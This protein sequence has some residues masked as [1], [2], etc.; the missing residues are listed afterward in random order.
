[1]HPTRWLPAALF[2]FAAQAQAL[3]YQWNDWAMT[4]NGRF[5]SGLTL[6]MQ[7]RNN[8]LIGKLNVPGQQHL[9]DIDNCLSF[10][11]DPRPNQRLVDATGAYFGVNGD[12]G[13]LNY[14]KH[15]IVAATQML[16]ADFKIARGDFLLR[17]RGIAYYD[18][19][20]TRHREHHT[21][22]LYQPDYTE[23]N[24]RTLSVFARDVR[25]MEA[26]GQYNFSLAGHN[27]VF[28]L[29][30]Q[31]VRW[32]ESTLIALNSLNEITPPNGAFLH[33]PGAQI[34][35]IFQPV[36][37]GLLSFDVA[38]GLSLDLLYQFR[39]TPVQPDA[40]GSFFSTSDIAG[41]G[42]YAMISLGAFPEDP[43]Q[44]ATPAKPSPAA[45]TAIL[46]LISSTSFSTRILPDDYGHPKNGGQYGAKLGYNADWLN[47]GTELGFYFLNYHSRLPYASVLAAD[48]S[49]ARYSGNAAKAMVDCH[50]FNGSMTAQLQQQFGLVGQAP[51]EPAP[52]DTLKVFLDY[53]EN[54]HLFG[55]SFNTNI[56]PWAVSGEYSYRPNLPLQVQI[57]DVVFGGLQPALPAQDQNLNSFVTPLGITLPGPQALTLPG[58]G[59]AFPGFLTRYRGIAEVQPHQ[60]LRGY[61]R[62]KVGQLDLT[63]IRAFSSNP[64][65]ADQI[66]EII[67]AGFTQIYNLPSLDR[68]QI[69]T[70]VA[71][72][73]HHG[74]GADGT[75][76]P[77]GKP[78][79]RHINP[80]Q[81]T[82][83]FA[84]RFA[85]G[86]RSITLMEY[87]DVIFGWSLKPQII[88]LHDM[89]GIAP[90]PNQNF[91]AGR[92]QAIV[93][94]DVNFTQNF[95]GHVQYEWY[96]G[97]GRNNS[98]ID[99]DNFSLSVAYSF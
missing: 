86:L 14:D 71:Y 75:G 18:P 40:S 76:T 91:I 96:W 67:E 99:R 21:N 51:L 87:N 62:F 36:P 63:G 6:R 34:N 98:L 69:E 84:T 35:Q 94:T 45:P 95:S 3:D 52:I 37:L 81:Q 66:I 57:S 12:N 93:G 78:D 33:M 77:D 47:N 70:G 4:L 8:N 89:T 90:S 72:D 28:S 5:S 7:D 32:G 27:A 73:T 61:E 39:W 20:N 46:G 1:M 65:G 56:G 53:P 64:F 59:S 79:S 25:L 29:G 22:T 44:K 85:W 31:N 30:Q 43:H 60:L 92:S 16:D 26:Y 55:V 13:D 97:G 54:I 38:D 9:C 41:G 48:N 58:A 74:P 19:A 24:S 42:E 83:G 82:T 50:G 23:R 80:T 2:L 10:T 68:L 11:N 17:A 88:L 49:C 15:S